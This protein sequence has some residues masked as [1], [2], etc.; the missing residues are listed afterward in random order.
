MDRG[1]LTVVDCCTCFESFVVVG[2]VSFCIFTLCLHRQEAPR[3]QVLEFC[4]CGRCLTKRGNDRRAPA[5]HVVRLSLSLSLGL[6]A[7]SRVTFFISRVV[8]VGAG[9]PPGGRSEEL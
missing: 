7:F 4:L 9:I 2:R 8:C 6:L 5:N 1:V 3:V